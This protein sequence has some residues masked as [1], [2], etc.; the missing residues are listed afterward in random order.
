M[1]ISLGMKHLG[2]IWPHSAS[3]NT[4]NSALK[5]EDLSLRYRAPDRWSKLEAESATQSPPRLFWLR[6]CVKRACRRYL[7]RLGWGLRASLLGSSENRGLIPSMSHRR[8]QVDGDCVRVCI[9]GRVSVCACVYVAHVTRV[10]MRDCVHKR[11]TNDSGRAQMLSLLPSPSKQSVWSLCFIISHGLYDAQGAS[12]A[13]THTCSEPCF[14]AA[15]AVVIIEPTHLSPCFCS[16]CACKNR[17]RVAWMETGVW[18][19]GGFGGLELKGVG[20]GLIVHR[21]LHTGAPASV[22]SD[23]VLMEWVKGNMTR[24]KKRIKKIC[25]A[26]RN[27]C[28]SAATRPTLQKPTTCGQLFFNAD[29]NVSPGPCHWYWAECSL[30]GVVCAPSRSRCCRSIF[31]FIVSFP[32]ENWA[33]GWKLSLFIT[34]RDRRWG[35]PADPL[36]KE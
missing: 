16:V 7:L 34:V 3:D 20:C 22:S 10:F 8:A 21:W 5:F 17:L 27:A 18:M 31:S 14:S 33:G 12:H 23:A 11:C 2:Y 19:S 28:L 6:P 13:S 32:S 25:E 26:T 36:R 29:F 30:T 35:G 15:P 9:H 24:E 1:F 4:W